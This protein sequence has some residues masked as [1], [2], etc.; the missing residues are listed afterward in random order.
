MTTEQ[1]LRGKWNS[2]VG[3]V[4][5][6]YG[7]ITDDDLMHWEGDRD[8]LIGLIQEKAGKTRE[9][10]EAFVDKLLGDDG[11]SRMKENIALGYS[12]FAEHARSGYRQSAQAMARHPMESVLTSFGVGLILGFALGMSFASQPEPEPTW[13]DR[14]R[15]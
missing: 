1:E 10:A 2:I 4:K 5:Q 9:Q 7:E 3:A 11:A 14:F 8:R 15:H 6:K 13:R 12:Q